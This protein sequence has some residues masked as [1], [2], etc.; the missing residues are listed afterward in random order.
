MEKLLLSLRADFLLQR[1]FWLENRAKQLAWDRRWWRAEETY[2]RLLAVTPA[3]QEALFD[4]S[5]VQAAQGLGDRERATLGRLLA[6]DA[7]NRLAAQASFRRE[8]RSEPLVFG[9]WTYYREKGRDGLS[10][11]ERTRLALGGEA[12]IDHRFTVNAAL[13]DW[14]ERPD[15]LPGG[16]RARGFT[17]GVGGAVSNRLAASADYTHKDYA[18]SGIGSVDTGG[19]RAWLSLRDGVRAGAGVEL[20]EELA[21][22]FAYRQGIR[23]TRRWL[24]A[25]AALSRRAE[26]AARAEAI[27]YADDN[28]GTHLWIAPAYT[29]TD[30]PRAF[31]TTLTFEAR[32]TDKANIYQFAGP[33]LVDITHPYWTPR[34]YRGVSLTLEWRHDLAADFFIGAQEHWYD[35][36]VTFGTANDDNPSVSWA[37]DYVREWRDRWVLRLG[38]GQTF[39]KQWDDL[40]AQARLVFRF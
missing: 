31:K 25:E 19:A 40:R 20:V 4:L 7:N 29:W 16:A 34:D 23:S 15:G 8:R 24:G 22:V 38:A 14:R 32:D 2:D 18:E 35:V 13:L 6:H 1:A 12:M 37:A 26:V 39:S 10:D 36:R 11:I 21:S 5:Q 30:H 17:A 9:E 3:N 33:V 27:D 28:A